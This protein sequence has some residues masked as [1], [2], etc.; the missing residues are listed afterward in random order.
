MKS[1][2]D[3]ICRSC[4]KYWNAVQFA[5]LAGIFCYYFA[6][7]FILSESWEVLTL[8]SVDDFAMNDAIRQMQK[9]ILAG[10]WLR[11]FTF[12]EYGYGNAFW[13]IN[14]I[15]LM[16]L[17]VIGDAQLQIITGRQ[18][19]LLY[20][21]GSIYL[22]GLIIVKLRPD[23]VQLKYPILITIASMPMVAI[24]ST[25]LHV[26]AQSLYF[27]ILSFYLLVHEQKI[28]RKNIVWSGVFGGIAV[29]LKLTGIFLIPLL[30]LILL[31]RLIDKGN[32]D[33]L[34]NSAI[35]SVILAITAA[36]C[37]APTLLFFPI[38]YTEIQ[39]TY[40]ILQHFK[41]MG[42]GSSS[43]SNFSTLVESLNYYLDLPTVLA[44]AFF[45]VL[46]LRDDIKANRY[47]S[48][49]MVFILGL[50]LAYLTVTV[51]KAPVYI[52]T[53]YLSVSFIM[54]LG[55]LGMVKLRCTDR[56][57]VILMY[58][59]VIL[60][61]MYGAADREKILQYYQFYRIV[62]SE[63]VIRQ[64]NALEEMRG[65]VLPIRGPIRVLQD[66]TTVF[67]GTRFS[68][69]RIDVVYNYGTLRDYTIKSWGKFDY[70]V[71]NSKI[72]F[73]QNNKSE[74][75]VRQ[76]LQSTGEFYGIHYSLIYQGYD[77]LLYKLDSN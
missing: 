31:S 62:D 23:A 12:F 38:F 56:T 7:N 9:I 14:A 40:N 20:V 28:T 19:S 51:H 70:I 60:G 52:A 4:G 29:G 49:F 43:P 32:G 48:T 46:L 57:K 3:N 13:L 17:Y 47:S 2:V 65:I 71:L 18:I 76:S 36:A 21:F 75:N 59:I 27:G 16:P 15:L 8:R 39:A 11:V 55:F 34:K 50:T 5:I 63:K 35:F 77:T 24:I 53:Y 41:S 45:Y 30:G 73:G 33:V 72:Y 58:L 22:V 66:A 67:P 74:E 61:L 10:D 64:L 42:G 54:P 6:E 26:N 25:K 44:A 69:E 1:K 68:E 37:F